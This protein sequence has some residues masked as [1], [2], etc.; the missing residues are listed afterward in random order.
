MLEKLAIFYSIES[1]SLEPSCLIMK[2]TTKFL[3]V[4]LAILAVLSLLSVS[5]TALANQTNPRL[6][7]L[8]VKLNKAQTVR[9]AQLVEYEIMQIWNKSGNKE[10]DQR[11]NLAD[12]VMR[13]GSAQEALEIMAVITKEKPNFSE[14]WNLHATILFLMGKY[15]E[16]LSSIDR[17]LALE[18]RHFGALIGKGHIFAQQKRFKEALTVFKTARNLYPLHPRIYKHITRLHQLIKINDE[19]KRDFI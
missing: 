7:T 15:K 4:H 2:L 1:Y 6:D 12:T 9:Q 11:M 18:P 8:F 16:S 17:T 13:N 3:R 10:I 14:A 5:T 19:H